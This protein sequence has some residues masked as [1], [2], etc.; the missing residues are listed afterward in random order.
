MEQSPSLSMSLS[1][2]S[3]VAPDGDFVFFSDPL[4]LPASRFK[5]LPNPFPFFPSPECFDVSIPVMFMIL[6]PIET[7]LAHSPGEISPESSRDVEA[8]VSGPISIEVGTSPV[9]DLEL[10]GLMTPSWDAAQQF[11]L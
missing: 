11:G 8:S 3:Y 1:F 6:E 5:K 7:A 9:G 4:P 10:L 2:A